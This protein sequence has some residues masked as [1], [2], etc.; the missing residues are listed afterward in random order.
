MTPDQVITSQGNEIGTPM[1]APANTSS[2]THPTALTYPAGLTAR[3]VEVLRLVARGLTS[4]EIALEL[5]ISEK[6]LP[7]TSLTFSTKRA[8]IIAQPQ[9]MLSA[10]GWPE[11]AIGISSHSS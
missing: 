10:T 9:P 7:I 4:G 5:K 3:E 1:A 2:S 6:R 11:H 8:A